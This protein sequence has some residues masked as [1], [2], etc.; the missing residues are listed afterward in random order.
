[1]RKKHLFKEKKKKKKKKKAR[2]GREGGGGRG[3]KEL[4]NF[5][6]QNIARESPILQK[7]S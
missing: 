1:M 7:V 2:Q 3:G 4:S 6:S 5:E